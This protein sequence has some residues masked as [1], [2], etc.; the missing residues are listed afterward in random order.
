MEG[1]W[2]YLIVSHSWAGDGAFV[3]SFHTRSRHCRTRSIACMCT[4]ICV[5]LVDDQEQ[6]MGCKGFN[7]SGRSEVLN[8]KGG[9][10]SD[11]HSNLT[12]FIYIYIP[13]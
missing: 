10:M 2:L 1:A 9:A 3:L 12:V 8:V 6:A 4:P 13:Y 11:S 5:R 7:V